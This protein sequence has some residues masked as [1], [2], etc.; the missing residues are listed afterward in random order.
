MKYIIYKSRWVA[1]TFV[2]F[3]AG[4][5]AHPT[6]RYEE[7]T[8]NQTPCSS[9]IPN[10]DAS[11]VLSV[12]KQEFNPK[13]GMDLSDNAL[14]A[15][16]KALA[17]KTKTP[18]ELRKNLTSKLSDGSGSAKTSDETTFDG[19]FIITVSKIPPFN[20]ADKLERTEVEIN[21]TN[22]K[23]QSWK[24]VQTAYTTINAG[25]VE[26]SRKKTGEFGLQSPS[27]FPVGISAKG[28]V[29]TNI[30]EKVTL[31]ERIEDIT[32]IFNPINGSIKIIRQGGFGLDLAGNTMLQASIAAQNTATIET[33]S[34]AT[35]DKTGKWIS[36]EKLEVES[37]VAK[38]PRGYDIG[39]NVTLRYE[40]RHV[41]KGDDSP[42]YGD[43]VVEMKTVNLPTKS[44]T[45]IP[46]A[47]MGRLTYGLYNEEGP[48]FYKT[49][50]RLE[51]VPFCFDTYESANDFFRYLNRPSAKHP[52]MISDGRIGFSTPENGKPSFSNIKP[53]MV[54]NLSVQPSCF[55][56]D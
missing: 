30:D 32:P 5:G 2:I 46:K 15:F 28:T 52:E 13:S 45:L 56:N 16:I 9:Q 39:A 17:E 31:T 1:P 19:T 41:V 53:A 18:D 38:V 27:N 35:K 23:I 43:D 42:Q 24:A 36:P 26:Y 47:E 6:N 37:Q 4:C 50:D 33:F 11:V 14:A 51:A 8:M 54:K 21:L 25:D 49:P 48:L 29:E 40:L 12:G 34:I 44:V 7:C 22:A 55:P 10:A 20:P 3:F